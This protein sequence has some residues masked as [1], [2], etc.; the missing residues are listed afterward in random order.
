[1][2]CCNLRRSA[3]EIT[4]WKYEANADINEQCRYRRNADID[5]AD[6]DEFKRT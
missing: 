2:L 3:E 4:V 6:K 5:D 1:M